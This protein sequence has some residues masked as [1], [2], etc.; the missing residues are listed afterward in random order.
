M[1][2]KIVNRDDFM[3][4]NEVN[5]EEVEALLLKKNERIEDLL[6]KATIMHKVLTKSLWHY[7]IQK[8][9]NLVFSNTNSKSMKEKL[10]PL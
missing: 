1:N 2:N 5:D 4:E 7:K 6:H 9:S 3:V 8:E 10:K